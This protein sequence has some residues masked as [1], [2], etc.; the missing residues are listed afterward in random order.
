MVKEREKGQS[1][2]KMTVRKMY[3]YIGR[4]FFNGHDAAPMHELGEG[5][6]Y[7]SQL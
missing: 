7:A 6:S 5:D 4:G 3:K 2:E 1:L